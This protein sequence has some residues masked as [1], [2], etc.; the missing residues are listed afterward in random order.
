MGFYLGR[1][2]QD[3]V[4]DRSVERMVGEALQGWDHKL[5]PL[6][7]DAVGFAKNIKPEEKGGKKRRKAQIS[8]R[9]V[10]KQ[11]LYMFPAPPVVA[12]FLSSAFSLLKNK[13]GAPKAPHFPW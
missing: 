4:C 7:C 2:H 8:C 10:C 5:S 9:F 1:I 3:L 13:P 11:G 6:V 12:G